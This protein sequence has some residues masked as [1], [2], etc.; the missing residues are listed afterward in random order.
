MSHIVPQAHARGLHLA[1]YM[2][3]APTSANNMPG[4][5]GHVTDDVTTLTAWGVDMIYVDTQ[6]ATYSQANAGCFI[7]LIFFLT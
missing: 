3:I 4:L 6:E 1:L 7:F 5:H 2:D